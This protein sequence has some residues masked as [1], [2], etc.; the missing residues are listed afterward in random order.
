[1]TVLWP[2]RIR[3]LEIFLTCFDN[4]IFAHVETLHAKSLRS[5]IRA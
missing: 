3:L 5:S 4:L 2:L 1:M